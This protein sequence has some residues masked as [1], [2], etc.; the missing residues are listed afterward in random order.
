MPNLSQELSIN[1]IEEII[2]VVPYLATDIINQTKIR[3]KIEEQLNSFE[4]T[5]RCTELAKGDILEKAFIFLSCKKLEGMRETT[6]YNYTLLFKRMGLYFIKPTT[7]IT[8][9]DLRLFVEKEY[10]NNQPSSKNNKICKIKAFFQWLQDEG[11]IIQNPSKNLQ[12]VKEPYRKRGRIK[13]ID[14]EKMRDNCKTIRDKALFEFMISTGCRVTEV[15]EST[16]SNIN[17]DNNSIS[18]IGKGDK[19]RVVF[20]STRARM[21]L[22]QYIS[23]REQ[24]GIFRDYLFVASKSP[25]GNLGRRSIEK[26]VKRIAEK[27]GVIDNIFPH[28]FRHTYANNGVEHNVPVHILSHLMGHS[29]SDTT[30]VYYELNDENVK[31]EYRKMAL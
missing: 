27:S 10:G 18:V 17:W 29:S 8:T 20:F 28:L 3:N 9:V 23:E 12:M 26:D 30:K 31:H 1:I 6:R 24:K 7:T 16:I 4:I 11:Y 2:K 21:F 25:H 15:S 5:S 19:E 13:Q 22:I 14:V